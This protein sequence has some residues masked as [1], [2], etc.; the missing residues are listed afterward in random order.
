M[1]PRPASPRSSPTLD[2]EAGR[3]IFGADAQ[4]YHDVRAG[5]PTALFEHLRDPAGPRPRILEIGPGSGLATQGL[6]DLAPEELVAVESDPHF[7]AYLSSRLADAPIR[8]INAPFPCE[9]L[10][11]LFDL[12]VC[13]AAFHWLEPGPAL[14]AI[15]R[16]LRPGGLWAMWWNSYLNHTEGDEFAAAALEML[17]EQQVPLPPSFRPEGHICLDVEGQTALL[18]DA[19]LSDIVHLQWRQVRARD[20]EDVRKLFGTFSFVRLLPEPRQA[21]LLDGIAQLV[22]DRFGGVAHC[23][24]ITSFYAARA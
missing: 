23:V 1:T 21:D 10:D 6:L 16:L 24:D 3:A 14:A 11:G 2:R 12:A 18:R 4:I 22:V 19:G 8:I 17:R 5:Y 15:R 13:A 9:D 7:A 20:A